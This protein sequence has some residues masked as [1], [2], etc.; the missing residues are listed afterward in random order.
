MEPPTRKLIT[1]AT[2]LVRRTMFWIAAAIVLRKPQYRA[3][4]AFVL[5]PVLIL[6]AVSLTAPELRRH[7]VEFH[8][9]AV[10]I[11]REVLRW[12]ASEVAQLLET[13]VASVNSALQ[14]ARATMAE[15]DA[16]VDA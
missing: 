15:V 13:T 6:L 3:L 7:H 1:I 9:P 8:N 2:A 5:L 14:R 4:W 11:L 16:E 10:L 12:E